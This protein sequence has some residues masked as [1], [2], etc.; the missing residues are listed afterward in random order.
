[1]H[2]L[3]RTRYDVLGA[4]LDPL[5]MDDVLE[6]VCHAV[7]TRRMMQ[8]GC[9]NAAKIVRLQSE[10]ELRDGLWSCDLVTADG[11]SVVWAARLLGLPVRERVT[12]VD[13]MERLLALAERRG[14]RVYFLGAR[15]DILER[16]LTVLRG[17]HPRLVIAGAHH[18]YFGADAEGDVV[19]GIAEGKPDLLFVALETPQKELFLA[20]HREELSVPFAMGVGGALDV[21]AGARR[22]APRWAQRAGLEWAF[23][24][25][26]EPRRLAKRYI[27]G[28]ARFVALVARAALQRRPARPVEPGSAPPSSHDPVPASRSPESPAGRPRL[29]AEDLDDRL[30]RATSVGP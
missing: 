8:H 23:R 26:Q 17:R 25:V 19:A 12:G 30:A 16:A 1:M 18:G 4:P 2:S 27:V 3:P 15:P 13:L 5:G 11:Q 22:R 28:N 21:I 10:P 20:R 7:E 29:P 14:F 9:V 24:F 6:A